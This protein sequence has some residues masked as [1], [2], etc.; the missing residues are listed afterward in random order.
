MRQ[1]VG[2]S[3]L[4]QNMRPPCCTAEHG[5]TYQHSN[6]PSKATL[7]GDRGCSLAAAAPGGA[8]KPELAGWELGTS[9]GR[10]PKRWV[11]AGHAVPAP[12][13][14]AKA[15]HISKSSVSIPLPADRH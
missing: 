8:G 3:G 2:Y 10:V 6:V 14:G 5:S 9:T 13:V 15:E 4:Q 11:H 7:I 1:A 12:S